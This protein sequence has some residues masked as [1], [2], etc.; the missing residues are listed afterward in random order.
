MARKVRLV[1]CGGLGNQLFQYAAYLYIKTRHID[2]YITPDIDAYR[3]ESYHNGF[4]VQKI[5]DVEFKERI[6]KVEKFRLAHNSPQSEVHRIARICWYRFRGYK[7]I[8][9]SEVN[10]VIALDNILSQHKRV[11]LAGYF[12]NTSFVENISVNL[13]KTFDSN[14]Y[15][16]DE[17]DSI[18]ETIAGR[19]SVSL[20]IRRG[21]YLNIPNYDVFNGLDYY[22]RSIAYIR[23]RFEDPIFLIFSNDPEWV[24]QNLD[25]E[26]DSIVVTCNQGENSYRDML[27]MSRCSHNIIANSTFS[28]WGAWL[29][30]NPDKIVICPT[31]WFKDRMS[32]SMVPESWVKLGN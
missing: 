32:N 29:N 30:M 14:K 26:S 7:T 25:L 27:L 31:M 1:F 5:F 28:W 11:Q 9:D 2:I 18:L 8:Y 3:Y 13:L 4:E 19:T 23:E 12:Q 10:S 15:L 17:C 22:K 16:G 24:K 6:E 21:D 20:H